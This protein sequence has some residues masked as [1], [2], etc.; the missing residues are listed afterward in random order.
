MQKVFTLVKRYELVTE[1]LQFITYFTNKFIEMR[2][3]ESNCDFFIVFYLK[4]VTYHMMSFHPILKLY[5]AYACPASCASCT[6]AQTQKN[7]RPK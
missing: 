1:I 4:F 5:S 7:D 3:T 2:T 6:G